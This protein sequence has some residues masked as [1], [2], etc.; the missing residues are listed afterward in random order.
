[1]DVCAIPSP[2]MTIVYLH[3]GQHVL[4]LDDCS[5][6]ERV[7]LIWASPRQRTSSSKC[8][9]QEIVT[10]SALLRKER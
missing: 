7:E 10:V 3:T 8:G 5:R 9:A 6:G 1:M 4:L 2:Y